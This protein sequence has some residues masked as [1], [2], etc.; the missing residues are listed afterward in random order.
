MPTQIKIQGK[1]LGSNEI[2]SEGKILKCWGNSSQSPRPPVPLKLKPYKGEI[3]ELE[4]IIHHDLWQSRFIKIIKSDSYKELN[5]RVIGSHNFIYGKKKFD[6]FRSPNR[7]EWELP[8]NLTEH[9]GKSVGIFGEII[10]NK[11]FNAQILSTQ[12]GPDSKPTEGQEASSLADLMQIRAANRQTIEK[13]NGNMGSALGFKWQNGNPTKHPAVLIFVPEKILPSLVPQGEMIPDVLRGLDGTWCYTD[14]VPRS[15]TEWIDPASLPPLLPENEKLVKDL[16]SG[17]LGLI[18]G[19]RIHGEETGTAGIAIKFKETGDIG[20]LTNRHIAG[21]EGTKIAFSKE[22][23]AFI[24]TCEQ[25]LATIPFESWYANIKDE[26]GSVVACDCASIKII[27]EVKPLIKTGLY[28]IGQVGHV[29]EID[30]YSMGIIGR[31]IISVGR[32]R[33]I[34]KGSIIAYSYEWLDDENRNSYADFLIRSEEA[35]G[36]YGDSGKLIVTDDKDHSA[37]G[38]FW[39]VEKTQ[40]MKNEN[41]RIWG[42]ATELSKAFEILNL[43]ILR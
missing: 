37:V 34:Q 26:A 42:Y 24:G 18:G 7:S 15:K 3:V 11:I 8:L 35:V 13:I 2:L 22:G 17:H 29:L 14:V 39:G 30:L 38:L 9:G 6:C 10:G 40:L 5:G 36:Y 28:A 12:K 19:V 1:V 41:Q 25:T 27:D 43:E 23:L 33:G 31:K 4:G 32:T 20:L 21:K 16:N